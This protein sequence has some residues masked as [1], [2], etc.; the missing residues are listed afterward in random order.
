MSGSNQEIEIKTNLVDVICD[1][2]NDRDEAPN[3]VMIVGDNDQFIKTVNKL[4]DSPDDPLDNVNELE[5]FGIDI[6]HE[7]DNSR[8]RPYIYV[9]RVS[10]DEQ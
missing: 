10:D 5:V 2:E 9:K 7:F 6:S 8:D 3:R 1:Y 4:L